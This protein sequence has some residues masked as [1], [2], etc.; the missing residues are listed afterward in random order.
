MTN[1]I[2]KHRISNNKLSTTQVSKE[3]FKTFLNVIKFVFIVTI[4]VTFIF[5]TLLHSKAATA[6]TLTSNWTIEKSYLP[7]AG[8][9]YSISCI[10]STLCVATR[11]NNNSTALALTATDR[12]SR[13]LLSQ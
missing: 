2:K 8:Y 11:H 3:C 10:S 9:P 13:W 1:L 4:L 5:P 12:G 6:T 7:T